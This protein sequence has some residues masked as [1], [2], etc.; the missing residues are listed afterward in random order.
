MSKSKNTAV[1]GMFA[2]IIIVLQLISYVVKIGQFNLS[3]VL[4]PIVLGAYLY[5]AKTG[6]ILGAIFGAVVT[7]CCITGLDGGGYILF[8]S[9]PLL[10]SLVCILKGAA[11][12]AVSGLTAKLTE[13]A[14][15]NVSI[16]L[17]AVAAPVVNTGIFILALLF[18]FRDTLNAWAG[19]TDLVTYIL[20]GLV[21][22]NFLIELAINV[23]FAPAV[24]NITKAIKKI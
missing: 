18:L 6:A 16:M 14:N 23:I 10:T 12:G 4:I 15:E 20:V 17:S 19:G 22:V 11:A 13:K 8:S 3:L 1:F 9:N 24:L 5:G 2:A 21:G 7:V